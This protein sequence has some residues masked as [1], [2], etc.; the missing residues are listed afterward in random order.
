MLKANASNI[1]SASI[2]RLNLEET[3]QYISDSIFSGQQIVHA[4]INAANAVLISENEEARNCLNSADVI[5]AD[6]QAVV[7]A[8][9][10]LKQPL[11]ER[12]PGPDLME[13]LVEFAF[14]NN[15]RI[16]LFGA[17]Q[18]TV[19]SVVHIYSKRYK[20][21]LIAGFRNGFFNPEDQS[22][23]AA[24]INA[25]GADLLFVAIPSPQKEIFNAKFRH[26]MPRLK[27]LMGVGGTFDVISGK[28]KRAPRWMQD[29]GLEWSYRL[30]KEPRRL[31]KRYLIGNM[32][33]IRLVYLE[34][35]QKRG[36][37][38]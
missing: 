6:G 23:I 3:V 19:E 20:P 18:E 36:R 8:S 33:F 26:L 11:P 4:C 30:L 21:E 2:S 14:L 27:L 1:L 32:K 35:S 12:V 34:F 38:G 31:W 25:S 10:I 37:T 17:E 15:I 29:N 28:V 24:E 22:E 5:S 9:R 16:F 7:W 13:R